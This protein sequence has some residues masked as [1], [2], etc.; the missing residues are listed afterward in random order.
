[1]TYLN[2]RFN[3]EVKDKR[4]SIQSSHDINLQK[5][6]KRFENLVSR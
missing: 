1:M 2:G 5:K 3:T 6:I 4:Y